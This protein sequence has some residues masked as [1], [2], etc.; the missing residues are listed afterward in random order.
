M[1]FFLGVSYSVRAKTETQ[2]EQ[3]HWKLTDNRELSF[4]KQ[5]AVNSDIL[6]EAV[7]N[8]H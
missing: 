4:R 7:T 5:P 8:I 6:I 3:A 1:S 2:P